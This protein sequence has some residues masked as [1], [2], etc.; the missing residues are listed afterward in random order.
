MPMWMGFT[1]H[2]PCIAWPLLPLPQQSMGE[3]L[4]ASNGRLLMLGHLSSQLLAPRCIHV[5]DVSQ[6]RCQAICIV[7]HRSY[8]FFPTHSSRLPAPHADSGR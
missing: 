4:S 1:V 8:T 7:V 5:Q 2:A 6:G 3:G